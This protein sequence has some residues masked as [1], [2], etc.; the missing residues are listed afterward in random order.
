MIAIKRRSSMASDRHS[1]LFLASFVIFVLVSVVSVSGVAFSIATGT[2]QDWVSYW[3]AGHLLVHHANPYDNAAVVQLERAHG[4]NPR[5]HVLIA[6]NPPSALWTMAPLGYLSF[7][8]GGLL[9]RLLQALLLGVCV[10]LLWVQS[11][12]TPGR[13]HLLAFLFIG[14]IACVGSGQSSIFALLGTVVFLRFRENR[15]LAAGAALSLCAFKPH[16]FL[17]FALVML[18]WTVQRRM[19]RLFLG[20]GAAVA[21]QLLLAWCIYPDVFASYAHAMLSDGIEDQYM[22]AIAVALRFLISRHAMWLGFV[23]ALLGCAWATWYFARK[24]TGWNWSQELPLLLLV[25]LI[26]APYAWIVD[27]VLVV[28]A[29]VSVAP[30]CSESSRAALLLLMSAAIFQYCLAANMDSPWLLWQVPAFFGWYL[31]ARTMTNE[32]ANVTVACA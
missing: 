16:L 3:A 30:V 4:L 11:G 22:P 26:A 7:Y 14:S 23:P 10:H 9:W 31:Y 13:W 2:V 24:R 6:R 25:S 28:P 19:Y 15:P 20:L 18:L 27:G 12:R 8:A 32:P 29:I 5:T 21:G 1:P 17:P